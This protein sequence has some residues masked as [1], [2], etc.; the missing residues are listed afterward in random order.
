MAVQISFKSI[1]CECCRQQR[2][3]DCSRVV[4]ESGLSLSCQSQQG[5]KAHCLACTHPPRV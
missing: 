5:D 3:L 1:K 2:V 4:S